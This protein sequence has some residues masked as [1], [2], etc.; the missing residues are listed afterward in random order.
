MCTN[1]KLGKFILKA[2]FGK[3][4]LKNT[5]FFFV[6]LMYLIYLNAVV[7]I[8]YNIIIIIRIIIL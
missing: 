7:S 6:E 1:W 3:S 8:R 4:R 2:I 5:V